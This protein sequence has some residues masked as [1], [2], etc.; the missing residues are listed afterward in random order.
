MITTSEKYKTVVS[1]SGRHFQLKIDIAGTEYTG[2]K[3]F[4]IKGGTN[5]SEQITF[6]D[7]VS[8]YIEFILTD[9]PKKHQLKRPPSDTIH[10]LGAGRWYGRV[11]KK[12][13][14]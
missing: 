6:G 8:S 5:S 3:S 9:V 11:D 13:C 10:W 2:I 12:R 1:K 7:A 4:K 14:I